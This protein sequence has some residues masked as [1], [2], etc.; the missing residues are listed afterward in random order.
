[1]RASILGLLSILGGALLAPGC[2][3]GASSGSEPDASD[4]GA[5]SQSEAGASSGG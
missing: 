3:E 1:M 5:A 2:S 4:A